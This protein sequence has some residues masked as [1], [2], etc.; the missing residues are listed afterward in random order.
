MKYLAVPQE[1]KNRNIFFSYLNYDYNSPACE[2]IH[3]HKYYE[4]V[5]V[6]SGTMDVFIDG[7]SYLIKSGECVIIQPFQAHSFHLNNNSKNLTYNFIKKY[8]SSFDAL[9]SQKRILN[10]I[11]T[12]SPIASNFIINKTKEL[13]G[14]KV[15][16]RSLP[17]KKHETDIKAI[18]YSLCS[19]F[20]K[21]AEF[22]PSNTKSQNIIME[23]IEY[24]CDNFEQN[25]SLKEFA[26]KHNYN[27]QY[28]SRRF[29][30]FFDTG[31]KEVLN[32]YRIEQ[33][34]SYL[35][36]TDQP[37]S[38]I[39]FSSGFQS[40]RSF[41]DACLKYYNKTPSKIRSDKNK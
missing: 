3:F 34:I 40:I 9:N 19:E 28:L 29:N 36:E 10:P 39:A 31:F 41:N 22:L 35:E 24:I 37:I 18:T 11:F 26:Q 2:K 38:T 23:V 13:F 16:F 4:F 21:N 32:R 20:L 7:V 6:E 15:F 1:E 5:L 27:Y 12:P 33:A 25:I 30:T 17:E 8:A 14:R